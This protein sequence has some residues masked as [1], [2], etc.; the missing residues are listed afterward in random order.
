MLRQR[1]VVHIQQVFDIEHV[2]YLLAVPIDGDLAPELCGDDKPG[3]P[4]LILNAE[5]PGRKCRTGEDHRG[6]AVMRW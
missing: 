5:L 1:Q 3:H 2:A 6:Q 4:A